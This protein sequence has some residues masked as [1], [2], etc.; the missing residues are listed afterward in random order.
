MIKKSE[1]AFQ[2]AVNYIP[3]GVN[4]PV[5][6]FK[7][8]GGT[9]RFIKRAKG[10]YL[11]DED[12]TKYIDLI[13]SWGP[14]ILGHAFEPVENAVRKAIKSSFSFGAP[15]VKEVEMAKLIC[16][17][18]PSVEMVRMVNSGTE[19]TMSAIRLARAYTGKNK[20]IKFEGCYHGH[21]DAFLISAG[22]G[23]LSL[24][25]PDSPGITPSTLGDTLTAPYNDLDAVKRLLETHKGEVAAL[26]IEPVVGNMGCVLPKE[27]YLQGLRDLCT[28]EGVVFIF[29]EVMTG[30]RLALGGA[31]ERFGITPDLTTMGKII[32]GGMP[33]GAYGGKKEIMQMVAP[34]GPMYQAG[35]LSGNPIA[36]SAGMAM[37]KHLKKHPEIYA[38]LDET[39]AFIA[40][41]LR[42][43]VKELGLNYTVNQIGSMY[44][45]FFTSEHVVDFK[46]AKTADIPAFSKYFHQMLNRGV[47]LAPSQFESLFLSTKIDKRIANKILRASHYS[48]TSLVEE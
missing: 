46:T 33:V 7:S 35:T 44:S 36:M 21:G 32:G 42:K 13:G 43:S 2:E 10:A 45:L 48:L 19:A 9:P 23:A 24:G 22:S 29:D 38:Q 17:L 3:G 18:V 5:R 34:S 30:F 14:M 25:V 15:T 39:G 26:I 27:G 4:S 37:L 1:K 11:T 41:G 16:D 20:I 12:N 8:V 6:A 47:Y 28:K 40:E 31:Q